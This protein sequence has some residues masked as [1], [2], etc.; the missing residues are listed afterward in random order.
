[1]ITLANEQDV[2]EARNAYD[3]L[4]P[5]QQEQLGNLT[6]L[7]ASEAKI[8]SLL[9]AIFAVEALIAALPNLITMEHIPVIDLARSAYENLSLLQQ[10]RVANLRF[11]VDA[12]AR[13]IA[14]QVIVDN[15]IIEANEI[16]MNNQ[17]VALLA[18]VEALL[19]L[20]ETFDPVMRELLSFY[21][22]RLEIQINQIGI[23]LK[24]L[25]FVQTPIFTFFLISLFIVLPIVIFVVIY[26]HNV[27][28]LQ[29]KKSS[30]RTF[31]SL[32]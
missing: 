28:R 8:K 29:D 17:S 15:F 1:V 13:I 26:Q 2:I 14:L 22:R 19:R 11:L 16:D 20:S 21:I 12:E 18:Q 24:V 4:Q 9:D 3:L 32:E 27:A 30:Y 7:I 6:Q 23:E 25:A 31:G 5:S 10:D